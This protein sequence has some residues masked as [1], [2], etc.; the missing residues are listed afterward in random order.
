MSIVLAYDATHDNIS[1]LPKG[2]AAGYSTGYGGVPW[3]VADWNAHPGAIRICQNPTGTDATADIF[4]VEAEA[5]TNDNAA[6]WVTRATSAYNSGVRKGQRKPAIYTSASNV[7]PLVNALLTHGV[8]AVP[9]WVA[10][11]GIGYTAAA[12]MVNTAYGP[13][14]IIG[15]QYINNGLYDTN[16]FESEWLDS[17]HYVG[18]PA[19]SVIHATP[20]G[21]WSGKVTLTGPAWDSSGDWAT[22]WDCAK[23][24]WSYPKKV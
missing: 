22:T 6:G 19:S 20:P 21:K 17:A 23:G 11:W 14:P 18:A 13:Y 24:A 2:Q 10:S 15:V 12:Q 7:T 9:L 16:V 8:K 3:T 4:D 5:G 1:H